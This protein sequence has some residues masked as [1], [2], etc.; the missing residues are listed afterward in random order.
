MGIRDLYLC[1]RRFR[2]EREEN[3]EV[4]V[5]LD[6]LRHVGRSALFIVGVGDRQ[7]G[8]GQILG[9]GVGVNQRLE[10]Q[11]PD[12]LAAFLDVLHGAPVQN[13]VGFRGV[14]LRSGL[15]Y[16]LLFVQDRAIALSR[17][18]RRKPA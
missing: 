16:L 2:Q 3:F 4:L 12:F 11:A 9:I 10:A 5:G 14:V 15:I 1:V 8:L 6:R 18:E 7:L 17:A 13:L